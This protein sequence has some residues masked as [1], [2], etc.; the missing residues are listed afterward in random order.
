MAS[1]PILATRL[2]SETIDLTGDD[3]GSVNNA[4]LS[5]SSSYPLL[6]GGEKVRLCNPCVP[7]PQPEPLVN[8]PPFQDEERTTHS[9]GPRLAT[10][11]FS[12]QHAGFAQFGE[13][14]QQG[15]FGVVS[16]LAI[17][18]RESL[19]CC[20]RAYGLVEPTSR[21][22]L[23]PQEHYIRVALGRIRL[24]SRLP[25]VPFSLTLLTPIIRGL[26]M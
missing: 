13:Q 26:T 6:E 21:P 7:D 18:V 15:R 9:F 10:A 1:S 16:A 22:H 3:D 24:Q 19:T 23:H 20:S 4:S 25:H 11:R 2:Q 14:G 5:R 17:R 12:G 8:F